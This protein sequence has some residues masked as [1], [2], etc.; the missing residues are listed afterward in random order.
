[1]I[2]VVKNQVVIVD[3]NDKGYFVDKLA[4]GTGYGVYAQD[5]TWKAARLVN[6]PSFNKEGYLD[7]QKAFNDLTCWLACRESNWSTRTYFVNGQRYS[8]EA[9]N[10][11][12]AGKRELPA[13]VE[14]M[15]LVRLQDIEYRIAH[16]MNGAY[17]EFLAVG[18]CL[19]EAKEAQLVPRG[20]WEAWVK[21]N[22]GMTE[23]QAQRLMQAA[24]LAAPGSAMERLPLSKITTLLLAPEEQREALAEKALKEGTS[25]RVLREEI[26][27]LREQL[28][29]A[30]ENNGRLRREKDAQLAEAKTKARA[31]QQAAVDAAVETADLRIKELTEQ[32]KQQQVEMQ[33]V[34]EFAQGK[35]EEIQTMKSKAAQAGGIS[36]EAQATIDRLRRELEE[37]EDYAAQQAQARQDAQREL[38]DLQAQAARGGSLLEEADDLD[39]GVAVRT[40]IGTAG[41]MPHMGS[42]LA[43][44]PESKRQELSQYVEMIST[45]VEG[46]RKA[47]GTVLVTME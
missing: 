10:E 28:G 1:M 22:T 29:M 27:L 17:Q 11:I 33:R 39:L 8:R 9:F 6:S 5:K 19:N 35:I 15:A 30:R 41:V 25:V 18:R 42:T 26:A 34:Q 37:A 32:L 38:L 16:H 4:D 14:P 23:R 3:G 7:P 13:Q 31:E 21:R 36:Q 2:D 43:G 44:L 45:W 20:Q 47:L 24:R 12:C 46:A 40:F